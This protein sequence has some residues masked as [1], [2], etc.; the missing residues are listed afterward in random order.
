MLGAKLLWVEETLWVRYLKSD[1]NGP[2]KVF[3]L[4]DKEDLSFF[5]DILMFSNGDQILLI[6]I[7]DETQN[8]NMH[9]RNPSS[10]LNLY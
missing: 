2:G 4:L 6:M 7:R 8:T 5:M 3:P 10:T 1:L 9:R